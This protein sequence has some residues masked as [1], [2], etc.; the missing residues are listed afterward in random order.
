MAD[1]SPFVFGQFRELRLV[2]LH[3][4][5]L[6]RE[7]GNRLAH[8]VLLCLRL[9]LEHELNHGLDIYISLAISVKH[10]KHVLEYHV[11]LPGRR[12]PLKPLPQLEGRARAAV[13]LAEKVPGTH[14][15]NAC[16]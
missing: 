13:V 11:S 3:G 10:T 4:E 2:L 7:I 5:S 6:T 8:P 1:S 16:Q 12:R 15:G 9:V 14:V